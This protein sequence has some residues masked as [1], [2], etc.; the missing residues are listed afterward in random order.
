VLRPNYGRWGS[1]SDVNFHSPCS[2]DVELF[3]LH[4]VACIWWYKV[5]CHKNFR[6]KRNTVWESWTQTCFWKCM[7]PTC[8]VMRLSE[9]I[10]DIHGFH[11]LCELLHA[12][13][14][15]FFNI[16]AFSKIS[17]TT[18]NISHSYVLLL[19]C[20]KV[21]LELCT[22]DGVVH[23]CYG[24]FSLVRHLCQLSHIIIIYRVV[25]A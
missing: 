24:S 15:F 18:F 19:I 9:F 8:E 25:K 5:E 20:A 12:V 22:C 23:S 4:A 10:I 3:D 16:V 14:I 7:F 21:L 17:I 11:T 13:L 6:F 2:C 1:A